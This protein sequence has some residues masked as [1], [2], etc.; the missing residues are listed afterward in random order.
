MP[1]KAAHVIERLQ[2]RLL[3]PS[4]GRRSPDSGGLP[5]RPGFY[6]WWMTQGALPR[7]P[8]HPHP[9]PEIDFDLLYV[10][11]APNSATSKQTLRSRV[12]KNHLNG[13]TGSSTFRLSLAAL[14][15]EAEHFIPVTTKTKFILTRADNRRLSEWQEANLRLTWCEQ[16]EPWDG[17]LERDVIA[18]MQSPLNLAENR[19]HPFHA[20]MSAARRSFRNAARQTRASSKRAP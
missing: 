17:T 7:V 15:L 20:T 5:E 10:G 12:M 13:N 18:V 2:R 11:I 8:R 1:S 16:E 9:D 19:S 14:L 3:S 6:S 4:D